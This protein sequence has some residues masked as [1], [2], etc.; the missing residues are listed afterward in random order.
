M[1]L[2]GKNI[3]GAAESVEPAGDGFQAKNPATGASL[4]PTYHDATQSEVDRAYGLAVAALP[5]IKKLGRE[6]RAK[7]LD[8]IAEKLD[9]LGDE[10]LERAEAETGKP[11][12]GLKFERGRTTNQLR[13]F[14]AFVREGS[15]TG[16]RIEHADSE[17]KPLPKPDTRMLR[18]AVGPVAV[19][20]AS[21]FPLAFSVPGGD[22]ASAL[23]S[24]CPVIVKAHPA[25]PGTS[26][27]A[28]RAIA[29]AVAECGFPEGTFS[30][31]HGTGHEIGLAMVRHPEAR[32]VAFTGSLAGGR[33]LFDAA[34]ARPSPIPVFAEMGS[35]NPI[36]VLPRAAA[37]YGTA[38]AKG[39]RNSVTLGV[40]QFCTC[41]GFLVGM[42]S[43]ELDGLRG[44]LTEYFEGA[45]EQV[46]LH[47]GIRSNFARGVERVAG[48]EGVSRAGDD[49][50][51]AGPGGAT[52]TAVLFSTDAGTFMD[53]E[54]I[55]DEVFGP[56]TVV[57]GCGS[58]DEMFA[59]ASSFEG[60][61]TATIHGTPEDLEEYADLVGILEEKAGRV[62]VGGFPTG[63]EVGDA[64]VHGGPYPAT[65]DS[66]S[67]SV[68]TAAIERFV[69][70]VCYQ[71]FPQSLLP[72]ELQDDNVTRI[73]R[74]VDG[75]WST[76]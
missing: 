56:S 1:E 5:E 66:R 28:G 42:E 62:I 63:V 61:L 25:H 27:M 14:A 59:M 13:M 49:L 47:S 44:Q 64:M 52:V 68:G 70:P 19:F 8:C 57:V 9:A 22:T 37:E 38:I 72:L 29:E 54:E 76:A 41:P 21:N 51:D 46:M 45:A 16:A 53:S 24:G 2:H 31:L 55:R 74:L 60:Q 65:T 11:V 26:E 32:A 75:E 71:D 39:M 15:W 40:G 4:E 33:A 10:W 17:R 6:A 36:F 20:G 73:L 30:L 69:R 23:A 58:R 48:V 12:G 18:I 43:P 34:A 35:T 67:T 3:I 50:T 7:L